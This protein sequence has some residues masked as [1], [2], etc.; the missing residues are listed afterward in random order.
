MRWHSLFLPAA[1]VCL[2]ACDRT[3]TLLETI[4][5]P[6]GW[7]PA[8]P[9]PGLVKWTIHV[10][11]GNFAP[12]Y[13]IW[14]SSATDVFA[15]GATDCRGAWYTDC[16]AVIFHLAGGAW[17]QAKLP[18]QSLLAVWG[19]SAKDVFAVGVAGQILHYDGTGWSRLSSGT[20]RSLY[21]IWGNSAD[22]VFAAG[23]TGTIL[24]FDGKTWQEMTSP[25]SRAGERIRGIWG[26]S[27]SDVFAVGRSILHYNGSTWSSMSGGTTKTLYGVW[28]S[29]GT[30][31]F[32]VGIATVHDS[33]LG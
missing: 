29:S 19:A 33:D 27:A 2:A 23:E 11:E 16:S 26:S 18:G 14:G 1:L 21:A 32:A 3:P 6:A 5:A 8:S 4:P 10:S 12:V 25:E 7:Q 9:P 20:D 24:R 30:D 31:V 15:V 17:E 28:G 22:T 13:G